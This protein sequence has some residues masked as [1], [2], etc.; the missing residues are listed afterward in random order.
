MA[1]VSGFV[2]SPGGRCTTSRE[3]ML[4]K[5]HKGTGI[6]CTVGTSTPRWAGGSPYS[7]VLRRAALSAEPEPGR[8]LSEG[9]EVRPTRR[10]FPPVPC[11]V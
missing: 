8:V 5:P 4:V 10:R 11:Q 9:R 3:T 6:R 7:S 1:V 2:A